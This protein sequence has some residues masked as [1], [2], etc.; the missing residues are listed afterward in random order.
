GLR[1]GVLVELAR[2]A[3][4]PDRSTGEALVEFGRRFAFDERHARHVAGLA[5]RLYDAAARLHRLPAAARRLLEAA[6][7]LHDVGHSVS[8]HRHHRHT[9]YLVANADLPG[10]ADR[11]RE[12]VALVARYHRRSAP[13]RSKADLQALGA[14]ELRTVRTLAALLRVA[15][16]LDRSH[17]QLVRSLDLELRGR[18][19][20][21]RLRASGPVDLEAWDVRREAP[22]FRRVFGRRLELLLPA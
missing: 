14:A 17:Q 22:L 4:A 20:R 18:A 6:A 1:H 5:L 8:P 19:A 21:L 15:D 13:S 11:E 7:L 2:S 10:L 12:L 3:P 16:A 9:Y